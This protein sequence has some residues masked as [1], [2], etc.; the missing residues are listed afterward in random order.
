MLLPDIPD[1]K[2]AEEGLRQANRKLKLLSGITR[3]DIQNQLTALLGYIDL[4]L[5][6]TVASNLQMIFRRENELVAQIRDHL[7]QRL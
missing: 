4:S 3:H 5:E 2:H 6:M 1:Q 7:H